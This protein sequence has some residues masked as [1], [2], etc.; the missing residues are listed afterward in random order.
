MQ[1][2]NL[3]EKENKVHLHPVQFIGILFSIV[4]EFLGFLILFFFFGFLLQKYVFDGSPFVLILSVLVG[5][6]LG[7]YFLYQRSKRLSSASLKD[8]KKQEIRGFLFRREKDY[9]QKMEELQ[10]KIQETENHLEKFI[11]K[12]K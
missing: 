4:F 12:N 1:N 2:E 6:S 9:Q 5:F 11:K 8:L 10:K 3:K 7:M